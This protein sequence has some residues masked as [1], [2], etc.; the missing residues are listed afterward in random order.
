MKP[1]KKSKKLG[2]SICPDC[3]ETDITDPKLVAI[4]FPKGIG[5]PYAEVKCESCMEKYI[6]QMTWAS[7][8]IFDQSGCTVVGFSF[9]RGKLLTDKDISSFIENM[10]DLIEDFLVAVDDEENER[11]MSD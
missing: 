6:A 4:H 10:D 8:L 5:V 11:P 7:A 1:K 9:A 3:G 2:T